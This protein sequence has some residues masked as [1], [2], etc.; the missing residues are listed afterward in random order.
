MAQFMATWEL[1]KVLESKNSRFEIESRWSNHIFQPEMASLVGQLK[2][3]SRDGRLLNTDA[4]VSPIR[5]LGLL[6]IDT[7][8]R[9]LKLDFSDIFSKGLAYD[10]L[11]VDVAFENQLLTTH[12]LHL[13]GPSLQLDV[14]GTLDWESKVLDKKLAVTVPLSR[15]LVLPAAATGGL[16]A[17]A[18]ALLIEQ[19]FGDK[20]DKLTTLDYDVSGTIMEPVIAGKELEGRPATRGINK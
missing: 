3:N 12:R 16:P 18:T 13:K 20:L 2:G 15:N 19:V 5:F 9:R 7:I 6:N 17:A 1:P 4:D 11:D 8:T 14:A 10:K